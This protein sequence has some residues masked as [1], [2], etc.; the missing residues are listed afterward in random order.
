MSAIDG[1]DDLASLADTPRV[2]LDGDGL[3]AL[4]LALGGA[5][6]GLPAWVGVPPDQESVLTDREN[7]PLA[8][9]RVDPAGRQTVHPLR[10][11]PGGGGPRWDATARRAA[12]DV[13]AAVHD[14]VGSGPV[15]AVVVDDLP[16]RA[17]MRTIVET[18]RTDAIAAVLWAIPVARLDRTQGPVTGAGLA[19]AGRS[20]A[21]VL[22]TDLEGLPVIPLIVPWPGRDSDGP[23]TFGDVMAAYGATTTRHLRDLRVAGTDQQLASLDA[24]FERDVRA[25]YPPASAAAILTARDRG[26]RVGVVVFF[27]GLSGSG[28]S[29]IARALSDALADRGSRVTLLDGDEVRQHLSAELG[30]DAASRERNIDRIAYVASLVA[31][32]GGIAVAAPIAPFA[33]GRRAARTMAEDEGVFLL[34]HVDTPLAVCE[35]RDRKGLYAEARAGRIPEFTGISSP[36]EPPD[37]ADV[38]ID[39]TT[40]SVDGCG[41]GHRRRARS[42]SAAVALIA[43][44]SCGGDGDD[45]FGD[46]RTRGSGSRGRP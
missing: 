38:V 7:T 27:T 3:D 13:R 22:A 2:V 39:T 6:A 33:A 9:V 18:V 44:V 29:T 26:P 42:A 16:T 31:A 19:A 46:R 4:E 36:Y 45:A 30:F 28:K 34:V 11:L 21:D 14:L 43:W 25:I 8:H 17:D 5:I 1:A 24:A 37:D 40:T 41:R 20:L 23:V 12:R 35:A 32:H 15:L 10:P